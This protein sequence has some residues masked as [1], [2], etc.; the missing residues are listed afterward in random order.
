MAQPEAEEHDVVAPLGLPLEQVRLDVT[1]PIR[2]EPLLVEPQHLRG[3]ID[4]RDRRTQRYELLRPKT[5][6]ACEFQRVAYGA[7]VRKR[8]THE[9]Y[10]AEPAGVL[11]W[12]VVVS[13]DPM[14]PS[15]VLGRASAVVLDLFVQ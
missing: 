7:K 11:L 10:F 14:E 8:A 9:I 15:V 12:A 6:A 4:R 3:G 5:R 13:T 2:S 1:D